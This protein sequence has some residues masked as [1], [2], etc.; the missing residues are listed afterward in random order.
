ML[1]TLSKIHKFP[2]YV[3]ATA[4]TDEIDVSVI[5][6]LYKHVEIFKSSFQKY[7]TIFNQILKKQLNLKSLE[8]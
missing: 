8:P 7:R 2:D 4:F 6:D 3:G 1:N 5:E